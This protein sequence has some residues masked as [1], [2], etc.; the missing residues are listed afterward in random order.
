MGHP[1][2]KFVRLLVG[3]GIVAAV[4]LAAMLWLDRPLRTAAAPRG[5]ISFELA[6]SY[7]AARNI[8]E[9]WKPAGR[10]NAALSLWLDYGFLIAYAL[11]L[12]LLCGYVAASWPG[13]YRGIRRTGRRLARAQWVAALLDAFENVILQQILAGATAAILP[14]MAR[15]A[16]LAKFTLIACGGVYIVL[17][18]GYHFVRRCER[19]CCQSFRRD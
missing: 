9:S 13:R 11:V 7:A 14:Q 12:A 5:I 4:L 18:G 6:G 17:A 15:W 19:Y 2:H 16:A 1:H 3:G 8:I 10:R